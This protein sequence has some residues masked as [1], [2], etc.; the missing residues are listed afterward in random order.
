MSTVAAAPPVVED[1][2]IKVYGHTRLFYWWPVWSLGFLLAFLTYV[3]GYVMAVVPEGTVLE[4][5]VATPGAAEPR[6]VLVAPAGSTVPYPPGHQVEGELPQP[7]LRV[8]ASN[9]YGVIF[10]GTFLF[11]LLTTHITV[12]GLASVIVI[13][14]LAV[15]ALALAQLGMW[16]QIL[17]WLGGLD[18]RMNA[19][20]YLAFAIPI[21]LI[22]AF[23]VLIYDRYTYLIFARGQVRV[24]RE[25]G[26]GEVAI[27][28]NGVSLE[29]KRDDF[30]RHWL[31]GFGAG[32]LRVHTPGNAVGD[33]D[34]Y[35]V[36]GINWKLSKIQNLLREKE[37][38]HGG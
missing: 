23:S 28:A 7:R 9:N 15:A 22:W 35:N 36:L 20:G 38:S 11:V 12:R 37:V 25:I 2:E 30:F 33:F 4:Q 1:D 5:G 14:L 24:R 27:D 17:G 6:D 34:L 10:V 3:D 18:V 26:D 21:F 19:G 13:T 16:D 31:L 29:K 32:D 8:A